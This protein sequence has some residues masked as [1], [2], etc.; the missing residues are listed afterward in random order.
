MEKIRLEM[1]E[2]DDIIHSDFLV[3]SC[4]LEMEVNI[5]DFILKSKDSSFFEVIH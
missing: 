3:S 2:P 5:S 1:S 4:C